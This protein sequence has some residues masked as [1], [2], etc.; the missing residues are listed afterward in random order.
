[1]DKEKGAMSIRE[2]GRR[3]GKATAATHGPEFYKG[4]G[5]KGGKRVQELIAAGRKA[6]ENEKTTGAGQ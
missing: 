3:G 6:Q 2:A 1:V 4:I 5:Q